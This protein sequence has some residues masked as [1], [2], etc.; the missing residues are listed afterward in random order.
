M[1]HRFNPI[2]PDTPQEHMI[3]AM[4]RNFAA[5]DNE[6][7]TKVFND[8]TNPGMITGQLPNGMFG[9]LVYL[10]GVPNGIWTAETGLKIAEPGVDVLTLI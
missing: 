9:I 3:A 4:N 6:A 7:V 10:D 8:G 2:N 5:L 1:P